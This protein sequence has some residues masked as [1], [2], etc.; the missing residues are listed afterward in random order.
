[1]NGTL[2]PSEQS[3]IDWTKID[4]QNPPAFFRQCE[5]PSLDWLCYGVEVLAVAAGTVVEAMRDL[6][7]QP[8]GVAPTNLTIPE[9]AGNHVILDLGRAR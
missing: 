5:A 1:M 9:I 3:A 4:G 2:D 8:P 6:P 7:D